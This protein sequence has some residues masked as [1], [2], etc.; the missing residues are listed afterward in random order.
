MKRYRS[1]D[2]DLIRLR[3]K[4]SKSTEKYADSEESPADIGN[5][6]LSND[7]KKLADIAMILHILSGK[8]ELEEEKTTKSSACWCL[9]V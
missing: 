8:E 5:N 6:T 3:N 2:L 4:L 9:Y 7:D 1:C